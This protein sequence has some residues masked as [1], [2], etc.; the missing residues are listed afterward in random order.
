MILV[1]ILVGIALL[2]AIKFVRAHTE[3]FSSPPPEGP[4][5]EA[6]PGDTYVWGEVSKDTDLNSELSAAVDTYIPRK[7]VDGMGLPQPADLVEGDA[8]DIAK[9]VVSRVKSRKLDVVT[10]EYSGLTDD[11][12]GSKVYEITFIAFDAEKGFATKLA[13]SVLDFKG[14]LF[15]KKLRTFSVPDTGGPKGAD[16]E[17]TIMV[18]KYKPTLN[19]DYAKL[20]PA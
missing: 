12:K 14:K 1:A 18:A 8:K 20:Y 10:I 15:V 4:K 3:T 17:E 16:E 6:G 5:F 11:G 2:A 19:L 9:E 13:L 7:I